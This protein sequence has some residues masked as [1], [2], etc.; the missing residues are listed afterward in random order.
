MNDIWNLDPI[1]KGFDDP[2]FEADL[3][4]LKEKVTAFTAFCGKLETV[5]PLEG[6]RGTT[7]LHEELYELVD[8]LAGYTSFRQAT[9][10]KDPVAG[11]NMGRIM[12][13]YSDLAAPR[14]EFDRWAGSGP[15]Q[16]QDKHP[17]GC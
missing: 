8:K 11:S 2:A 5:D 13:V 16:R 6:L 3:N 12:A 7:K 14:A 4:T 1:Y 15:L 17:A 9:D 10:T